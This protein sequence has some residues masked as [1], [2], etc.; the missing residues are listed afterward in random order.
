MIYPL[1]FIC[2]SKN[3]FAPFKFAFILVISGPPPSVKQSG[4]YFF[5]ISNIFLFNSLF[6]A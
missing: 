6:H 2:F 1:Q 3:F 4:L 5:D